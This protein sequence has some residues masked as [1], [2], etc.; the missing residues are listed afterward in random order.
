MTDQE[1]ADRIRELELQVLFLQH[2]AG[3]GFQIAALNQVIVR[4]NISGNLDDERW[5]DMSNDVL[6]TQR[7]DVEA[8]AQQLHDHAA[9][10]LS[11]EFQEQGH[12][13]ALNVKSGFGRFIDR[14]KAG[15]FDRG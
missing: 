14:V 5:N 1:Q 10:R 15:I 9:D 7:Q 2:L 11:K 13:P 4:R 3:F 6:Q 12:I 8:G